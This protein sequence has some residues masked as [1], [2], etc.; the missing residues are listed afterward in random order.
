MHPFYFGNSEQPLYGV[1]HSPTGNDFRHSAILIC[2]SIAH[3]YIRSHR[4]LKQ[5]ADRLAEMGYYVLRFD[6]MG[7]GDS[8]GDFDK[9]SLS[10]WQDNI[11]L[12]SE[13]LKAISGQDRVTV[14]GLRM[15]ATLALL[16]SAQCNFNNIIMWR[17]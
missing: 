8:S 2:N 10:D 15:G 12:A 17:E 3:E 6:Y 13:E 1:S 16:S 4:A 14:I 7:V 9:T 5:L 11:K